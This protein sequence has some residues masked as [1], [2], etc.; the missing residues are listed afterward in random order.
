LKKVGVKIISPQ[1]P[2]EQPLKGKIFVFTGTLESFTR[3]EA[4]NKV[5]ELGGE[6]SDSVS[7]RTTFLV[8]GSQAG[9]KLEKAKKLG[10]KIIDEKEFLKMIGK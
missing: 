4:K 3:E 9:S 1:K 2:K 6:V 10:V 8:V 5:R 7:K